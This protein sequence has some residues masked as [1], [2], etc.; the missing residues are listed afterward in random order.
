MDDFFGEFN[1]LPDGERSDR[2]LSKLRSIREAL[3]QASRPLELWIVWYTHEAELFRPDVFEPLTGVSLWT[4]DCQE[5][6]KLP[7]RFEALEKAMPHK[8]KMLGI[9]MFDFPS[10]QPVPNSLMEYQCELGLQWLREGRLDGMIFETN[11]V[12]G[13][14]LPS[15][16]WLC[17]WIDRVGDIPLP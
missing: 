6:P 14:G 17:D 16:K 4:W 9:Y 13:V 10:G 7:E 3:D 8:K 15:E 12:M 11:S 1:R 5:L 2:A